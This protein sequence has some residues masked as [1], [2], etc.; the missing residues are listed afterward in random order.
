MN[1]EEFGYKEYK[2]GRCGWV[3]AAIPLYALPADTALARYL[4]CFNCSA[5]TA[6]FVPAGPDDAPDGCS[7]QPVIVPGVW[8]ESLT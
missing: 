6:D 4:S 7:L 5:P 2:C 8:G 3:H 1:T